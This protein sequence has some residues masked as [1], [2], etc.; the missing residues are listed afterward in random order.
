MK[1]SDV[2]KRQPFKIIVLSRSN[3]E[4]DLYDFIGSLRI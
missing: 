3:K 2:F 4:I 1:S